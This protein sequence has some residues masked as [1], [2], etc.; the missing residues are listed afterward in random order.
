LGARGAA[1]LGNPGVLAMIEHHALLYAD[2]VDPLAMLRA[3][4]GATALARYW[5]YAATAEPGQVDT[6]ATRAYTQLM[7]ASQGLVAEEIL[8]AYDVRRH[9]RV[10][11][12]GGGD[13][14]FLRALAQRAPQLQ[15]GLFD[16]PGVAEQAEER[17]A[18]AGLGGRVTIAAGDFDRDPLPPGADLITLVRVLHDHDDERVD[19]LLAAA[20]A[21]LPSGGALLVAEPM[22][23]TRGA[24]RMGDAYF[25]LYLWA[26]GSGRPRTA[27]DLA[28]R[29]ERA[30]FRRP[31]ERRTRVPLQTRVLVARRP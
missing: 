23:G 20:Y 5:P 21:A 26:M 3:P 19:R 31:S 14:T 27:A 15:L 1:L 24:E 4:R 29:L 17:F 16:L 13:G 28:E 22:A 10:L 25:G 2:L 11:D 12:V 9:R 8:D 6:A 7:S 18:A 30:G